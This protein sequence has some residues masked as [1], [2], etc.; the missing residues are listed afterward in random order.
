MIFLKPI[1]EENWLEAIQLR[2]SDSQKNFVA[3]AVGI[4]ARAY[5]YRACDARALAIYADEKMVGLAMIRDLDEEP[6]CYELQQFMIDEKY[7]RRGYG[8]QA[9]RMILEQLRRD[10]QYDCV[11]VCVRQ[12]D[13]AALHLYESEGFLN[14]GYTDPNA[15]DCKNLMFDLNKDA[16]DA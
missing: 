7:Q 10:N 8:R 1:H 11:E 4:L 13:L 9:L 12:D 5:A 15:A 6:A 3:P 16:A 14:T 2:V